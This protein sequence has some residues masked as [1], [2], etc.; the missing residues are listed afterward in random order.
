MQPRRFPLKG[1]SWV[2]QR[3]ALAARPEH[4]EFG[5]DCCELLSYDK[6]AERG[7]CYK[8]P[9]GGFDPAPSYAGYVKRCAKH[10]PPP[11]LRTWILDIPI[12]RFKNFLQYECGGAFSLDRLKR[13][14]PTNHPKYHAA[15]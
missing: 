6:A 2:S 11:P 5:L 14:L 10:A 3:A 12:C 4:H 1:R 8:N 13:L 7:H 9:P 15:P